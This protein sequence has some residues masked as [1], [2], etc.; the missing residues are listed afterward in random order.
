MKTPKESVLECQSRILLEEGK[1]DKKQYLKEAEQ[2]YYVKKK[3]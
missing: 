3:E 1:D 2:H